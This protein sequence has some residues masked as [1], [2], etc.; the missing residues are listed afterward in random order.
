MTKAVVSDFGNE[1]ISVFL[2][3]SGGRGHAGHLDEE[4]L[5]VRRA[6]DDPNPAGRRADIAIEVGRAPRRELLRSR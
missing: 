1:V 2:E 5:Q 3:F 6:D 4:P